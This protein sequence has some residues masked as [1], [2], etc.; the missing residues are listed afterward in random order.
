MRLPFSIVLYAIILAIPFDYYN[1]GPIS[2]SDAL[3]LFAT[4]L[5]IIL[6]LMRGKLSWPSN[7]WAL[8]VLEGVALVSMLLSDLVGEAL[9]GCLTITAMI[10][11]SF[12][13]AVTLRTRKQIR[14]AVQAAFIAVGFSALIGLVQELVFIFFNVRIFHPVYISFGNFWMLRITGLFQDPNYFALYLLPVLVLGIMDWKGGWFGG[15]KRFYRLITILIGVVFALTFSRASWL[16]VF[17][18]FLWWLFMRN[19]YRKII[20]LFLPVMLLVVVKVAPI[21]AD[22]L[23]GLNETSFFFR[24]MLIEKSIQS[25]AK[26]PLIGHGLGHRIQIEYPSA[27]YETKIDTPEGYLSIQAPKETHNTALQL[28]DSLGIAGG[29]A[30]LFVVLTPLLIA[31][32][33]VVRRGLLVGWVKELEVSVLFMLIGS[34]S[35]S[36]LMTKQIWV[37]LGLLMASAQVARREIRTT[38]A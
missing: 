14:L 13:L 32:R 30:F 11:L 33:L 38:N 29:V 18:A 35:I 25:I 36:A 3:L 12:L 17:A 28:L 26:S 16:V 6:V 27:F 5:Y 9:R 31:H 34:I 7:A 24:L 1:L 8:A 20:F 2:L 4:G 19:R 22:K 15:N 10:L 21:A 23:I 37:F